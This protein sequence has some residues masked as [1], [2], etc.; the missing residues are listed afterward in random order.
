MALLQLG[1]GCRRRLVWAAS[2]EQTSAIG[3]DIACDKA[4]TKQL[5]VAAGIPVPEGIDVRSA[6]EAAAAFDYLGG[7][8]VVKPVA[9]NH[10]R[11]VFVAVTAPEAS[12]AFTAAA[13]SG[14]LVLVEEYVGGTDYRALVVGGRVVAAELSPARVIGDGVHDIAALVAQVNADP[15]RG[16]GHDR[17]LTRIAL[18]DTALALPEPPAA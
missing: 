15:R 8:V 17:P 12:T 7:P 9:G 10:G 4:V 1:Y 16:I 18:D 13:Q 11:D 14:G 5:L 3:V 6:E 2:T